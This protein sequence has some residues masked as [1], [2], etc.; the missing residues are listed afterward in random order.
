MKDILV[1]ATV[2]AAI[3]ALANSIVREFGP[4][5]KATT[6]KLNAEAKE[7]ELRIKEKEAQPHQD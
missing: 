1:N 6:R 4:T 7:I 5:A 3:L 2:I